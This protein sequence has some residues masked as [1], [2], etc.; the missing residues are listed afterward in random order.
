MKGE[1][2]LTLRL[3]VELLGIVA[4]ASYF[5]LVTSDLYRDKT[6][7]LHPPYSSHPLLPPQ[8]MAD[9]LLKKYGRKYFS[10]QASSLEPLDPHYETYL[11]PTTGKTRSRKRALPTGLSKKDLKILKSVRRRAHYLDKGFSVCGFRFGWSAIFGLI[12]SFLSF[13]LF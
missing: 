1:G 2:K 12:R 11:D 9:F 13:G 3:L 5:S 6:H 8:T 4:I 10:T 7:P